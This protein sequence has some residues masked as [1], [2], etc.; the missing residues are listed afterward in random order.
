MLSAKN[1]F[2]SQMCP[3]SAEW[4]DLQFFLKAN[5]FHIYFHSLNQNRRWI[6]NIA[7][8]KHSAMKFWGTFF[9]HPFILASHI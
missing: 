3:I 4:T 8:R 1:G 2:V 6:Q 5:L 7:F 9:A